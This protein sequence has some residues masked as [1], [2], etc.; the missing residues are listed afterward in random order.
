MAGGVRA[1][2]GPQGAGRGRPGGPVPAGRDGPGAGGGRPGG[3]VPA[4]LDGPGAGGGPQRA[5]G[6]GGRVRAPQGDAGGAIADGRFRA[7]L[8]TTGRSTGARHSVELLA[9]GHA[10]RVYFSRHRPDSDWFKNAVSNPSVGVDTGG[11]QYRG[12]ARE[13]ADERLAARISA[14]KYPGQARASEKR[15]VLEVTL[16]GPS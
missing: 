10:G 9:V 13:V 14:L 12:T 5:G 2:G 15:A 8:V 6:A 3:P 11:A 4:G 1:G 7:V 16:D